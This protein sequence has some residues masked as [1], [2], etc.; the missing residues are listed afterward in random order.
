[1]LSNYDTFW[2]GEW[3]KQ[4]EEYNERAVYSMEKGGKVYFLYN[5]DT[6]W[7]VMTE[8]GS[9]SRY[10]SNEVIYTFFYFYHK[11]CKTVLYTYNIIYLAGY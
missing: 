8:V 2:D 10:L 5:K 3:T 11:S 7:L 9:N 6:K 1:M 4:S